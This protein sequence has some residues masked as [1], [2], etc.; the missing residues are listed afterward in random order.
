MFRKKARFYWNCKEKLSLAQFDNIDWEIIE[1]ALAKKSHGFHTW[2]SKHHS[3]WCG[4]GK[5]MKQ[6]GFWTSDKC[7]C[8]LTHSENDTKHM[9][10]CRNQEMKDFR[11]QA[12]TELYRK[13]C[14]MDTSLDI[15]HP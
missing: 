6:W 5:N 4:I 8:C 15:L 3:G 10:K 9:F 2:F 14:K 7:P 13:L 11:N 1:K 12:Y